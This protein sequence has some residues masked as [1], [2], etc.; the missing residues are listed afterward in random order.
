MYT[1]DVKFCVSFKDCSHSDLVQADIVSFNKWCKVNLLNLNC[2]KC[3]VMTFY[4]H[5]P[6]II[7]YTLNLI[8]IIRLDEV[9]DLGILLDHK[10]KFDTYVAL[11]VS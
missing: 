4:R 8:P 11:T 9:N 7:S 10:L 6:H 1:N 3:K 2:P 5:L